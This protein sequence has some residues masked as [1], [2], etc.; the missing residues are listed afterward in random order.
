MKLY[1]LLI[2]SSLLYCGF[3]AYCNGKP[4]P[5]YVNNEP[6]WK[7][8][9]RLIKTHKF[10][11]LFEIGNGSSTMKLLHVYGNMYQMGF[12]QGELLKD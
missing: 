6:I 2:I 7:E 10:G 1:I 8:E 4:G 3:S 5:Y 12:A 9:P 11:K